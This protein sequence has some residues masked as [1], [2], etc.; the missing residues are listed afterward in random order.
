MDANIWGQLYHAT[1]VEDLNKDQ[2]NVIH[3]HLL[4]G[5]LL[6]YLEH[7]RMFYQRVGFNGSL[8]IVLRLERVLRVPLYSNHIKFMAD[9]PSSQFDDVIGFSTDFSSQIFESDRDNIAS[10]LIGTILFAL[11]W[12]SVATDENTIEI[13]IADAYK[14]NGWHYKQKDV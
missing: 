2:Q 8:R 6:V 1:E 4:L 10:Q 5:H 11:N 12:P 3:L 7:A 13:F 9:P 14:F